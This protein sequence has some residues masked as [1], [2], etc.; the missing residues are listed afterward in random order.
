VVRVP[1]VDDYVLG[2]TAVEIPAGEKRSDTEVLPAGNAK[3][4]NP[5][6]MGEPRYAYALAHFEAGRSVSKTVHSAD[7]LVTRNHEMTSRSEIA[8]GEMEIRPTHP[9]DADM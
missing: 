8:L 4:A 9:T 7:D 1:V 3:P 5:T 2:V 6:G